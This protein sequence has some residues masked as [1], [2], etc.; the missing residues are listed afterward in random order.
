[1]KY[2]KKKKCATQF[3]FSTTTSQSRITIFFIIQ[4]NDMNEKIN[5]NFTEIII[6]S[7]R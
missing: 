1:M 7:Y 4:P 5:K 3:N 6:H 2:R